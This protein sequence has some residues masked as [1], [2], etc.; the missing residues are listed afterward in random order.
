MGNQEV[1]HMQDRIE[2]IVELAAPVARVWRA[3]TDYKEFGAWFRVELHGPFV[4]GQVTTGVT[5][6][7]GY[8]GLRWEGNVVALEPERV[9]AFEWCPYEHDDGQD[10]ASAPKTRVE[11]RLE[12]TKAG[13]RLTI[14]ESGFDKLPDDRRRVDALRSNT[15]GWDIQARNIAEYVER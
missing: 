15:E 4:L 5:T 6:Y 11:F 9:F 3:L 14:T 7:P 12:P 10:F 1:A 13:T 2:K 8:E